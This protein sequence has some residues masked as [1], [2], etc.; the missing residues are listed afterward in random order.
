MKRRDFLR[1]GAA[2]GAVFSLGVSLTGC[3]SDA[4]PDAAGAAFAPDAWIRLFADGAVLVEVDRSEMGQGVS[5]A[6]PMLVAEEMDADWSRIRIEFAP[7]NQAYYNPLVRAQVTGGSTSVM[8]AWVPLREAGAKARTMLVAAAAASWGVPADE[9]TTEPGVVLHEQTGRRSDYGSLAAAAAAMPVP[10]VASLKEPRDY[11]LIGK[12]VPRL[13]TPAQV[14]GGTTFGM[15]AGPP[16]TLVA[17][18]ER[19]PVFGGRLARVND[20]RARSV[21]GVKHVVAI[22]QG[23]AVVAD[24]FWSASRGR[25]ALE[26]EWEDGPNAALDGDA[27]ERQL[28]SLVQGEGREARKVGR[29]GRAFERAVKVIEAEYDLPFLAHA[30]MEPMNCTADVRPDGVTL[31]VPTQSQAAPA[32]FGIGSRGVAARIAGV[33]ED[34]V[35]VHTTSLGGGFG[36]RSESDF[37]AE[38]VQVSKAVGAPVK[39]V[40]TREDDIR[41]GY[42]RPVSKHRV[43]AAVDA[44][45][46]PLAWHH[47]VAAP[48]IMARF[49]PS[50]VPDVVARLAGPM[51]GGVDASSVEGA[52]DLPYLIPNL[53]V[54]YSQA[55]L[56][57]PVGFWRS[58]GHSH[59]AFAVECFM[60]ELAAAAGRD[61]V[62]FRLDLLPLEDRLR[63]VLREVAARSGWGSPLP[64]GVGRG[65]AAHASFGSFAAQVAEVEVRDGAVRVRRVVCAFDCG[66]VVNPEIV[67]QQVE[68]GIVFGLTAALM[69]RIS[70]QGG[71]AVESNFH[72]YPILT[73]ADMP[74]I[75][76]VLLPSGDAPGGV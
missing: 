5:T 34:R 64:A 36:R 67:T 32:L 58:V 42:F 38:A 15:D 43:R 21:A 13:D 23:V 68:G 2:T 48:P 69:G 28:T 8:A 7:A 70:I 14:S 54:R 31:W 29:G 18:I 76:V 52:V 73:M 25:A 9:C 63:R 3:R 17:L 75:E 35:T 50:F 44:A 37:V 49:I 66:I 71:R 51:K 60:D 30:C 59:T 46:V 65:V 41:H 53:E 4:A 6:L 24:G 16:G 1:A 72:D 10:G 56:P 74:A 47:H 55:D 20:A 11:R 33:S 45:G 57:V 62:Q 19:P 61:P 22:E 27:I 39:V 12:S 26:V 40:W